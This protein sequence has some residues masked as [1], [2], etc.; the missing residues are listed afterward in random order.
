MGN[1][2]FN[3]LK[4]APPSS[5]SSRSLAF[6]RSFLC[7]RLWSHFFS[8]W[9]RSLVIVQSTSVALL[10]VL[11]AVACYSLLDFGHIASLCSQ[12]ILGAFEI[13]AKIIRFVVKTR[14]S[15]LFAMVVLSMV[16]MM[17]V[18]HLP[19]RGFRH[20]AIWLSRQ[21][22]W[23]S[24]F[25]SF[26]VA[27]TLDDLPQCIRMVKRLTL[28]I[29][30]TVEG[31]IPPLRRR[32]NVGWN[33]SVMALCLFDPPRCKSIWCTLVVRS[34]K[35]SLRAC[36]LSSVWWKAL[37]IEPIKFMSVRLLIGLKICYLFSNIW[38]VVVAIVTLNDECVQRVVP[39]SRVGT[40]LKYFPSTPLV[41]VRSI[42]QFPSGSSPMS[43]LAKSMFRRPQCLRISP[44]TSSPRLIFL[45]SFGGS[46]FAN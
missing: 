35:S 2:L 15:N 1:G 25:I 41:A 43:V 38:V 12:K 30:A 33:W 44:I 17:M 14:W 31:M 8:F 40:F 29:L 4:A 37:V 26:A 3:F 16:A 7:T 34:I 6:S 13:R 9:L 45:I 11:T 20:Q 36:R 42:R 24:I 23:G 19:R 21:S 46:L 18:P 28:S 22:K 10:L 27:E 32:R 5:S 39:C